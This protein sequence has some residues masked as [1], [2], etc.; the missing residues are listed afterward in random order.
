MNVILFGASGM[1]GG[2]VLR[3]CLDDPQVEAVLSVGRRTSGLSAPKMREW[4]L[5]DLSTLSAQAPELEGFDVCFFCLGVS[6]AGM[7]EA[8]YREVTLD[9]TVRTAEIL[10]GKNPGLTFCYV[11][12]QGTDSSEHGRIMWARVKGETENR[13]LEMALSAYMFRPGYVQPLKGVRSRTRV[14]QMFYAVLGPLFPI[15]ERLFPGQVTTTVKVGRAM[16][17]VAVAGSEKRILGP[18]DINRLAVAD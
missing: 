4:L 1:V 14:Y 16:I 17:R 6:A 5:P 10:L 18:R 13:L 15:L 11:S 2:G 8:A 3:E 9:L 12:G 7:T